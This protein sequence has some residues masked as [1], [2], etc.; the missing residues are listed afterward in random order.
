MLMS[1]RSLK[2]LLA[3][4]PF[5]VAWKRERFS[6]QQSSPLSILLSHVAR[7]KFS[8]ISPNG[9]LAV[10]PASITCYKPSSIRASSSSLVC[11]SG[12]TY[13]SNGT[14]S[15]LTCNSSSGFSST[16][17]TGVK[18]FS[19]SSRSPSIFLILSFFSLTRLISAS[20]CLKTSSN[21]LLK[22]TLIL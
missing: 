10:S 14:S 17:M 6:K 16:L 13:F 1:F 11:S 5:Q 20:F 21:S 8:T 7:A 2:S 18:T 15:S 12:L 22:A 9:E 4:Y 3:R 19:T